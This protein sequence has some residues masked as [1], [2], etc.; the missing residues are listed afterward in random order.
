MTEHETPHDNCPF[1]GHE[2]TLADNLGPTPESKPPEKGDLT[3]CIACGEWGL[4][5]E[6]LKM[7]RPDEME[8][9]TIENNAELW[10]H[11]QRVQRNIR[12]VHQL[13]RAR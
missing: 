11:M 10:P 3:F 2:L 8:R 7:R 12:M 13:R 1:C 6:N 4:F 5:D 9:M